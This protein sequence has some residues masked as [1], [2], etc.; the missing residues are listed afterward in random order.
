MKLKENQQIHL[1]SNS[2][3]SNDKLLI[4]YTIKRM[5]IE[6]VSLTKRRKYWVRFSMIPIYNSDNELSHSIQRDITEK[7]TR[8]E[9][10]N[11][12]EN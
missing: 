2:D 1:K 10:N 8:K 9:K 6:T 4:L 12:L 5:L 11:S 3:K 7:K